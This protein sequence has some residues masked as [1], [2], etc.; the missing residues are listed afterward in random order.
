[1]DYVRLGTSGLKVSRIALGTMTY[2]TPTDRWPWALNEEQSRP[3]IQKA[4]E[5]G[6]NFFDTANGYGGSGGRGTTEEILG[7]W[8]ASRPGVRDDIV[9]ATKVASEGLDFEFCSVLINY[10]L[11]WNPM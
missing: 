4:L 7:R 2:G 3:F 11:P 9:L 10:D 8:F 6:I 1:M 5:L